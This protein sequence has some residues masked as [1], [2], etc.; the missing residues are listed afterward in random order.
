LT[1]FWY[2]DRNKRGIFLFDFSGTLFN[3]DS[4]AASH[5]PLCRRMLGS[6]P[7]Q[8]RLLWYWLSANA[9]LNLMVDMIEAMIV[10]YT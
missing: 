2:Y 1:L 7:G 10:N 5:I 8:M 6:N 4:S 9:Q 3:T